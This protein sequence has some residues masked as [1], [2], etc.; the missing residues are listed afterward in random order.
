[1]IQPGEW[2][3]EDES[4]LTVYMGCEGTEFESNADGCPGGWYRTEFYASFARYRR[5]DRDSPYLRNCNDPLVFEALAYY[6][7]ECARHTEAATS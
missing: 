4:P 3:P 1:M 5:G 2:G 6:E 7:A